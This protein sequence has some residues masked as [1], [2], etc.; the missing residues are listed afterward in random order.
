M[1]SKSINVEPIDAR[2]YNTAINPPPSYTLLKIP[3]YRHLQQQYNEFRKKRKRD[4]L[5]LCSVNV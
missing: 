5:D 2:F 3:L 1:T 4:N